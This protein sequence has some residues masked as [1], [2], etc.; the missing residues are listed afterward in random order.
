MS[1]REIRT[2]TTTTVLQPFVWDCPG[3]PVPEETFTHSHLSWYQPS[4]ICFLHLLQSIASSLFNWRASV[5]LHN[6]S[7]TSGL[8][9]GLA[10]CNIS[11]PSHCLLFETHTHTSVTCFA[12]V[13]RLS[14]NHSLCLNFLLGSLSF[15]LMFHIRLTIL[16]CARWSATSRNRKYD[17]IMQQYSKVGWDVRSMLYKRTRIR[18]TGSKNMQGYGGFET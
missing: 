15:T 6:M 9:L 8:P 16:I 3:V 13:P 5:F 1:W 7:K 14:S 18:V 10:P 2:S 11:S 12:V 4:F 17:I